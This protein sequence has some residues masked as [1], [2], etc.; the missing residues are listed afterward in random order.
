MLTKEFAKMNQ[1][2]DQRL[3]S[4]EWDLD[5]A[6]RVIFLRNKRKKRNIMAISTGGL[7]ACA[8]VM[9]FSFFVNTSSVEVN[10]LDLFVNKQVDG[11]HKEVFTGSHSKNI[12]YAGA[13]ESENDPV[14]YLITNALSMR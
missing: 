1:E 7:A 8:S 6:S 9:F 2:I 5:V 10:D 11:T 13:T 12:I 14:D 3:Q 4:P